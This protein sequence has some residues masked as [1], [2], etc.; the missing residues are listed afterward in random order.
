[1]RYVTGSAVT[2]TNTYYETPLIIETI[3]STGANAMVYDEN[4][5]AGHI[6]VAEAPGSIKTI[7]VSVSEA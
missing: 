3:S 4:R 6:S 5:M 2:T 1:L 7:R